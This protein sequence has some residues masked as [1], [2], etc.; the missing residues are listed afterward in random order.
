MNGETEKALVESFFLPAK[1]DRYLELIRNPKGRGKLLSSLPHCKDLDPRTTLPIQPNQQNAS[2]I[3]QI[4]IG[5][6]ALATCYLVS[7]DRELDGKTMDLRDAL[8]LVIGYSPGTLISCKPGALG[9]FEGEDLGERFI[10][11]KHL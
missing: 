4:L 8:K 11:K 2:S 5:L 3:E 1:R 7:E 9:Y 10:L 6:G